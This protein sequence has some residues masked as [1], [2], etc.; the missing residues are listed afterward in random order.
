MATA[1][2]A[3]RESD[4]DGGQ[5]QPGDDEADVGGDQLYELAEQVR[6]GGDERGDG[7]GDGQGGGDGSPVAG[8]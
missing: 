2:A 7:A 4:E 5:D 6:G 1:G 8:P 3:C